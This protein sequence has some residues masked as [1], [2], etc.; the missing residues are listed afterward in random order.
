MQ[1][2]LEIV[3]TPAMSKRDSGT[4]IR[5][6]DLE[7]N[8]YQARASVLFVQL[9]QLKWFPQLGQERVRLICSKQAQP[10]KEKSPR[11]NAEDLKPSNFS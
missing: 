4:Q 9:M 10:G 6:M 5:Q 1:Q 2:H 11:R 3:R 8:T 7:K